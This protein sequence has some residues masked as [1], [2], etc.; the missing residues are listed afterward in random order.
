MKP[1]NLSKKL[2][3]KKET[4]VNLGNE[5]MNRL[6]AGYAAE[7]ETTTTTIQ[8]NETVTR[9][10][11]CIATSCPTYCYWV[12]TCNTLCPQTGQTQ[13]GTIAVE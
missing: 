8:P 10:L 9:C 12:D 3:L 2:S 4:I 1:K 7:E 11:S 6:L 13:T 5:D